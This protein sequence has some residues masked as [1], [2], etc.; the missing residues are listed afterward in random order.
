MGSERLA[1]TIAEA[2]T[3]LRYRRELYPREMPRPAEPCRCGRY[4]V[5]LPHFLFGKAGFVAGMK[6]GSIL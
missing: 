4:D 3:K 5:A 6:V 1:R 2:C